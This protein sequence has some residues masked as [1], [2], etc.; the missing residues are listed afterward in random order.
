MW[1]AS[2]SGRGPRVLLARVVRVLGGSSSGRKGMKKYR[3]VM[4][5]PGHTPG[6]LAV[7]PSQAW[8]PITLGGVGVCENAEDLGVFYE[9]LHAYLARSGVDGVKVDGQAVVGGPGRGHVRA[10]S[11]QKASRDA[12]AFGADAATG[13]STACATP[14]RTSCVSPGPTWR[15]SATTST[16]RTAPATP[17]TS[18][19]S[20][21]TPSSWARSSRRTGTCSS[22]TAAKPRAPRRRARRRRVPVYVSD[23]PATRLRVTAQAGVSEW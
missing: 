8:D 7:E 15:A 16:P 14:P 20:R 11:R 21:T 13:S 6:L 9:E 4:T 22:R 2:K 12:G 10:A 3:P 17:Y 23:A 18:P 1:L 19:T 5:T